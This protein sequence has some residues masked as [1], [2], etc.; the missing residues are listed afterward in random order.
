MAELRE[1]IRDIP[2]FPQPGIV[3]KDATPLFADPAALEQAV[4][5]LS[6]HARPLEVDFVVAPDPRGGDRGAMR[7]RV[8]PGAEAQ[9]AAV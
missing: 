2:D 8:H 1:L 6:Q 3:F 9:E 4:E 5:A 7:G